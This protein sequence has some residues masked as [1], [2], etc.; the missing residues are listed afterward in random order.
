MAILTIDQTKTISAK[1][2]TYFTLT[3]LKQTGTGYSIQSVGGATL[4]EVSNNN[5]NWTTAFTVEDGVVETAIFLTRYIRL[6]T[7]DTATRC[8]VVRG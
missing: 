8:H 5:T 6:T 4:V 3:S 7:P 1:P 2:A